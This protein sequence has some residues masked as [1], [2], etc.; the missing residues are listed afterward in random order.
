MVSKN[1]KKVAVIGSGGQLGKELI[2]VLDTNPG[3]DP[4]SLDH[5]S[6]ESTDKASVF[7][8]LITNKPD[9]VINCSAYV[10]VDDCEDHPRD[11]FAVN[12]IGAGYIAEA[13]SKIN[14]I[15]VYISTDYVFDGQKN[16]PYFENDIPNPKNVYGVS[17]LAGEQ[18]TRAYCDKHFVIRTSGLYGVSGSSG[19]GGN[20]IET[21]IKLEKSGKTIRV[22]DDQVLTPT[23]TVDLAQSI[24]DIVN[25]EAYGVYHVTNG[26]FCSWY[27][28]AKTIFDFK[29]IVP[30]LLPT[31]TQEYGAKAMRPMYSVLEN[32]AISKL[33]LT[34]LR[35]WKDALIE[36]IETMPY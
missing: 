2:R 25:T 3:F 21:M 26:G 35:H 32:S 19:K 22:V 10:G 1:N 18:L 6:I 28:F 24:P 8:A 12:T 15:C 30:D 17:K 14:A 16:S 31:T 11:A 9:I 4:I 23:Y 13:C 36:Y 29:G 34:P 27:E 20:F 5:S 7:D 33:G